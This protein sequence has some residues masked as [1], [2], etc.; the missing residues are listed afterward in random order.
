MA[1]PSKQVLRMRRR[2]EILDRYKLAQ[3]CI[4]CGY[5]ANP[6]ALQWD[7]REPENKIDTPHRM[8]SYSVKKIFEEARKCDIRCANCHTIKTVREKDY[9][10]RK[11][12][13]LL[14]DDV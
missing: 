6:Y 11:T 14:E 9:L 5:N 10:E 4:D 7:H 8:A 3:G 2:R 1:A 12:N 13:G